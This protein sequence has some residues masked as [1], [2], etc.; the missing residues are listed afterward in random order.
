MYVDAR[1]LG[2]A[3][4][5]MTDER[6]DKICGCGDHTSNVDGVCDVCRMPQFNRQDPQSRMEYLFKRWRGLLKKLAE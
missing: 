5:A 1:D 4:A 2:A 6:L 3:V